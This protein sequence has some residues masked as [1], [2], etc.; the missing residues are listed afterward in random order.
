[1][2]S[3][4]TRISLINIYWL[5]HICVFLFLSDNNKNSI[6][7]VLYLTI[8]FFL[9]VVIQNSIVK[10]IGL[11]LQIPYAIL[12]IYETIY[13]GFS[14]G[15]DKII[16]DITIVVINTV[17]FTIPI[18]CLYLIKNEQKPIRLIQFCKIIITIFV[19]I[20]F[21]WGIDSFYF[22]RI[23]ALK[24]ISCGKSIVKKISEFEIYHNRLPYSLDE[25]KINNKDKNGFLYIL[26]ASSDN[27]QLHCD[28]EH[29][30]NRRNRNIGIIMYS[31]ESVE[32]NSKTKEWT[33]HE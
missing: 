14:V 28:F 22:K 30:F 12:F 23:E 16:F 6:Y 11:I 2:I 3:T 19:V 21:I 9:T 1:M 20:F 10:I 15:E 8:A 27:Y 4:K 13:L 29:W 17:N 24:K 31:V 33:H 7:I 26:D 5:V 25:L 18:L 32:Y